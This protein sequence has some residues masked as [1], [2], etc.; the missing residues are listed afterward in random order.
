MLATT[1]LAG[2]T[3]SL[4]GINFKPGEWG[5]ERPTPLVILSRFKR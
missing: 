3:S 4:P 1:V 5:V 2:N